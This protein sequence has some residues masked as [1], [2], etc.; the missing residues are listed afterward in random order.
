M[1]AVLDRRRDILNP[2]AAVLFRELP[3]LVDW[4]TRH[5]H[6]HPE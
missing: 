3:N 1:E 2:A 4:S 5:G 6:Y